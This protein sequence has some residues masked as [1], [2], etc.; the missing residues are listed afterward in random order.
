MT[1]NPAELS[2]SWLFTCWII[3]QIKFNLAELY[4]GMIF[5]LAELSCQLDDF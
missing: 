1:F 5:N 4:N 3:Y 2:T